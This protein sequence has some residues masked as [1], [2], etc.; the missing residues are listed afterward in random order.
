VFIFIESIWNL[1]FRNSDKMTL[2]ERTVP[3]GRAVY[4]VGYTIVGQVSKILG[5]TR[6]RPN[7]KT[8]D[9][10][11]YFGYTTTSS[12]GDESVEW[13][14]SNELKPIGM[15]NYAGRQG[16]T[17]K[18]IKPDPSEEL[19][20]DKEAQ[21]FSLK[22]ELKEMY[23]ITDN[24]NKMLFDSVHDAVQKFLP[25][26]TYQPGKKKSGEAGMPSGGGDDA[27]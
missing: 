25:K 5:P 26:V 27:G 1:L 16:S 14:W 10:D 9:D 2:K 8:Q 7:P 22:H 17:W 24:R 11:Y 4:F 13:L 21:I 3:E 20:R 12:E 19:L 18:R 15:E 6:K 23:E